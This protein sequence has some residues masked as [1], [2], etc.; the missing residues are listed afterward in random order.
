[1]SEAY[2][3]KHNIKPDD[4]RWKVLIEE[5]T[6]SESGESF[7]GMVCPQCYLFL[8]ERLREA[9]RNLKIESRQAIALRSENDRL[10]KVLN[11]VIQTVKEL[12]GQDAIELSKQSYQKISGVKSIIEQG[13]L[14][15]ILPNLIVEL[16]NKNKKE[17]KKVEKQEKK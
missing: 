4:E 11:I 2:C 3:H 14:D 16:A 8:K 15:K 6:E 9:K 7:K 13:S 1:M 17:L 5:L 12:T 10:Q